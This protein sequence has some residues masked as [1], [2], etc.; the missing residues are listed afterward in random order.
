MHIQPQDELQGIPL[1]AWRDAFRTIGGAIIS[2]EWFEVRFQVDPKV[3]AD[4]V[5]AALEA[6]FIEPERDGWW[7]PTIKGRSL[8]MASLR[9]YKRAKV[10]DALAAFLE[11]VATMNRDESFLI[12]VQ[13][14]RVF[15]SFLG[16]SADLSDL[17]LDVELFR[18]FD[19]DTHQRLCAERLP[20]NCRSILDQLFWP[21]DQ[22]MK[23]LKA[24][25]PIL[26]LHYGDEI[27]D[28]VDS[29]VVFLRQ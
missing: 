2:Q 9:T 27:V 23:F 1:R 25:S 28:Q 5:G 17:D 18:K 29:K 24:R 20:A 15:G 4:L 7:R 3:A 11:R 14:V 26:S 22:A 10:E 12:G 8:A 21:E 19:P 13:R 6:G 16:P